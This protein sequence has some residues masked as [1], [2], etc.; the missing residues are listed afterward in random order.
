MARVHVEVCLVL[1]QPGLLLLDDVQQHGL[2]EPLSIVVLCGAHHQ[3]LHLRRRH[4]V[5]LGQ[6]LVESLAD[7]VWEGVVVVVAVYRR[8]QQCWRWHRQNLG[9]RARSRWSSESGSAFSAIDVCAGH[10]GV[11]ATAWGGWRGRTSTSSREVATLRRSGRCRLRAAA[12]AAGGQSSGLRGLEGRG[13]DLGAAELQGGREEHGVELRQLL[14]LLA[15]GLAVRGEGRLDLRSGKSHEIP[16]SPEWWHLER[17]QTKLTAGH[18]ELLQL[19]CWATPRL[20]QKIGEEDGVDHHCQVIG[21][22]DLR[23]IDAVHQGDVHRLGGVAGG[24]K[25]KKCAPGDA[26][27][28]LQLIHNIIENTVQVHEGAGRLRDVGAEDAVA[29]VLGMLL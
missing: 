28:L 3:P 10:G 17:S 14:R 21:G 7:A 11:C 15:P 13:Q 19:P 12:E 18:N 5:L 6:D 22:Y 27:G 1:S 29:F 26:K 23:G 24:D 9:D 2:R 4:E 25:L 8:L 20:P 16:R